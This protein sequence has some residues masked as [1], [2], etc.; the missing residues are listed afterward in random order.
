MHSISFQRSFNVQCL[1]YHNISLHTYF[2]LFR[3]KDASTI[4]LK[5]GAT[6][7]Y[8]YSA[9]R[10]V[11]KAKNLYPHPKYNPIT[12][13]NDIALIELDEPVYFNDY[14]RPICLPDPTHVTPA[15]T[16]C[17]AVGWGRKDETGK[18]LAYTVETCL[19]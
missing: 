15:G 2:W 11:R 17:Y 8:A 3:N 9:Y 10:Q 14:L 18:F 6:R 12:V 1:D 4:T 5:I 19:N 13:D 7:R 16:R